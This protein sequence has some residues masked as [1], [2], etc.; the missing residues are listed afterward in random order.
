MANE[1]MS[2]AQVHLLTTAAAHM[3]IQATNMLKAP[4]AVTDTAFVLGPSFTTAA[5]RSTPTVHSWP[6]LPT[7]FMIEIID[8]FVVG[9]RTRPMTHQ[10]HEVHMR[11]E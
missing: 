3:D 6:S 1:R 7:E 2:E 9:A 5:V 10:F 8:N 11:V 4:N